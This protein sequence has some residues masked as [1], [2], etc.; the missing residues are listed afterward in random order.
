MSADI[1]EN[2]ASQS[3]N[4]QAAL[5][6]ETTARNRLVIWLLLGSV[7]VMILNETMMSVALP[8]LMEAL[9]ASANGVQWLTTAFLLTMAVVIPVTG[10][11]IQRLNTRPLFVLAMSLF[12]LG[13]LA[14]ALA[15]NLAFLIAARV[16]QASGTAIMFP[17]L[18][19]TV[20]TLVPPHERGKTMGNISIVMSVAP[21]IGPALSGILLHYLG[22]RYLFMLVLPIALIA[23]YVG[24]RRMVNV[25][26][27][28]YV[29]VDVL[30][31][32]LSAF[33]FGGLVYGL[34]SFGTIGQNSTNGIGIISLAIGAVAMAVFIARQLALQK[35][36]R[37]LLDFRTFQS[38][39]FAIAVAMMAISMMALFGTVILLP[40]YMQ[41][42]LGID[43]LQT[44][45]MLLPG[46]L[47]MGFLGREAGKLYDRLGP[48]KLLV[49]GSIIVSIVLWAMTL[50]SPDTPFI[51]ILIGHITISVGL[52]LMFTPL[53]TV[54]LSSVKP[55]LYA[56][57]SAILGST[58][59]VA[60][61]AG[62]ALFVA[63]MSA[64]SASLLA[65]GTDKVL[66]LSQGITLAFT[67]GAVISMF[68]IVAALFI[69]RPPEFA[70][71]TPMGH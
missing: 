58:Q 46:G 57:G 4:D 47:V 48:T 61:A 17:L 22:W 41:N 31:V 35:L 25:T 34:S 64:R 16:V 63:I 69:R 2:A 42:V 14:G 40:I 39:N 54:S 27:P 36:D 28:R 1:A 45:L 43:T 68:A 21:A 55:Q 53:F 65:G 38:R 18:M 9:N 15:P 19:T 50:L 10:F 66:A 70:Q 26:T 24:W 29:P 49:P 32:I 7:F 23:L 71:D 52:A 62:V 60:G 6:P 12:A 30:S 13:T 3:G 8:P 33:A 44:G 11:L 56:H 67:V 5:S 20:M 59:Q 37:P 51:N